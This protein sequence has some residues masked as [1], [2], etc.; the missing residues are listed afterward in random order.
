MYKVIFNYEEKDFNSLT[1]DSVLPH[2]SLLEV[3]LEVHID[4]DYDCGGNCACS[5]CHIYVVE[6]DEYLEPLTP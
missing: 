2:N 1:L 3:A 6:G 4:L 5:S